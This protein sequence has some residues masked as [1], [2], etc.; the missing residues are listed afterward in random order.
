MTKRF[1]A[2]IAKKPHII[3]QLTHRV[4]RLGDVVEDPDIIKALIWTLSSVHAPYAL[5][6]L[7]GKELTQAQSEKMGLPNINSEDQ[8]AYAFNTAMQ[9]L[10][11]ISYCSTPV[12]CFDE[13]DGTEAGSDDDPLMEG[14]SRAQVVAN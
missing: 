2:E 13:L 8:G 5:N 3:D 9:I 14:C 10:N 6:W 4:H 1:T 12:V 7:S 11:L